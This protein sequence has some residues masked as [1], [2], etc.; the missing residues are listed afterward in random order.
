[1]DQI[2]VLKKQV[3]EQ[4]KSKKLGEYVW[5]HGIGPQMGYSFSV[6]HA[7][8]YSYIGV[9]TLYLATHF[10]PVYW[11]TACLIVDSGSLEQ[12]EDESTDYKK[13]AIALN[14]MKAANIKINLPDINTADF[15]FTPNAQDNSIVFGLKALV[16]VGDD[17]VNQIIQNRPYSSVEDFIQK[18]A[19]KKSTMISLIK[20]GAFDKFQNRTELMKDYIESIYDKKER[21]NL[22]N[23][24]ILMQNK[25][26]PTDND[27][28][29]ARCLFEFNRYLK[30]KCKQGK[31]DE[32]AFNFLSSHG[33]DN[34]INENLTLNKT[35]WEVAYSYCKEKYRDY[36]V[37]HQQELLEQLN[38]KNF[39]VEWDKYA[40][41]SEAGWEMETLGYYNH[42][43]EL[44]KA[45]MSK[46]KISDFFQLSE[47]PEVEKIYKFGDKEIPIF[48]LTYIAGTC[49]AKD[50][51]R[52]T[53]TLLTTTGV[54]NLKMNKDFF[55]IYDKQLSVV[56]SDGTKTV[57]DKSWWSRGSKIMVLG[58]RRGDD[59]VVKKYKSTQGHRLYKI[60]EVKE[61]G[62]LVL[63][64]ERGGDED[65]E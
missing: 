6:I 43:H 65:N 45:K 18:I 7:K 58:M 2:P 59:F 19:P 28:T 3:L 4:A 46:Y 13:V 36:I 42:P 10:N 16:N 60:L 24:N 52:N 62:D 61:N 32:R 44:S 26:L 27:Y 50:K 1:M 33:Y 38:K 54:V 35:Q 39:Q 53:V 41:G 57:T 40:T 55:N 9:Q 49:I 17:Q 25:L 22:Q 12:T 29:E 14:K 56:K 11:N 21:L 64:S 63:Q 15:G 23:L 30:A 8:A 51:V 31:L 37:S 34:C 48:K 5:T 47:E 20:A